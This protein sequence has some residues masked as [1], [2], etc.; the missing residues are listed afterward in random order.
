MR[1][2]SRPNDRTRSRPY[3]RPPTR[4]RAR[5][6]APHA[7][8]DASRLA[9]TARR[10]ERGE[11]ARRFRPSPLAAGHERH[12]APSAPHGGPQSQDSADG[13]RASRRRGGWRR[14]ASF[15]RKPP[16]HWI[17]LAT[18]RPIT[19]EIV[20]PSARAAKLSAIRC[21]SAGSAKVATSSSDGDR[22]PSTSARARAAS[23]NA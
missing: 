22:R 12:A 1:I 7:R 4:A 5:M 23:I 10:K 3:A 13:L 21:L 2:A 15:R 16:N 19:A 6:L 18:S 17:V 8:N 9:T 14:G 20:S 11:T